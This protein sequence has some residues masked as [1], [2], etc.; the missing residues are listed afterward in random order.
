[1]LSVLGAGSAKSQVPER[2]TRSPPSLLRVGLYIL[3]YIASLTPRSHQRVSR[4][5]ISVDSSL[6]ECPWLCCRWWKMAEEWVT[7]IVL[8]CLTFVSFWPFTKNCLYL[9]AYQSMVCAY[10][11]AI[12]LQSFSVTDER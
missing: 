9:F 10:K 11:P 12:L 7:K 8:T 6:K 3:S 2:S 4:S 5:K 1:M